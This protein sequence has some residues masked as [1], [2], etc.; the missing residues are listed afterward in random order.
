[1]IRNIKFSKEP[2]IWLGA[3]ISA[4]ILIQDL[5]TDGISLE[6]LDAALVALGAVIGRHY[7][8]PVDKR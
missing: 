3:T 6:S 1:M 4:L 5:M 7:V 2:I 8:S